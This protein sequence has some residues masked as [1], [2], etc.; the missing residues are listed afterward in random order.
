MA[1]RAVAGKPTATVTAPVV[2]LVLWVWTRGGS[3][4]TSGDPVSVAALDAVVANGM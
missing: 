4:A 1:R 2:D 3:V